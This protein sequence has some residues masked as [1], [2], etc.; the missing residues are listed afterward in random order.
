MIIIRFIIIKLNNNKITKFNNE[1]TSD[2]TYKLAISKNPSYEY[3]LTNVV[4]TQLNYLDD[5]D[6]IIWNFD[7]VQDENLSEDEIIKEISIEIDITKIDDDG[8]VISDDDPFD[9]D[10]LD[11]IPDSNDFANLIKY[12]EKGSVVRIF[13]TQPNSTKKISKLVWVKDKI[14]KSGDI[15]VVEGR[16]YKLK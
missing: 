10:P 16:Y 8:N 2:M 5:S 3:K 1:L 11:N 14:L 12:S 15:I 13:I 6:Y 9:D 4:G 7:T